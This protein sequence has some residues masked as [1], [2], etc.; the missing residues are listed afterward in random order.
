MSKLKPK[1]ALVSTGRESLIRDSACVNSDTDC[2]PILKGGNY[3]VASGHG[4]ACYGPVVGYH[5]PPIALSKAQSLDN[6]VPSYLPVISGASPP[7][8]SSRPRPDPDPPAPQN[9]SPPGRDP[10]QNPSQ[11]PPNAQNTPNQQPAQPGQS[12]PANQVPTVP[13]PPASHKLPTLT[14]GSSIYTPN[15]QSTYNIDG[16]PLI[17]GGPAILHSGTPISIAPYAT[18]LVIGTSTQLLPPPHA[19]SR[20]API[21]IA[22]NLILSPNPNP[23][24]PPGYIIGAQTLIP[25][26]PAAII[27]GTAVALDISGNSLIIDGT[28]TRNINPTASALIIGSET[29][30]R[31]PTG[32][33][34]L[35]GKTL[36]PGAAAITVDGTVVSLDPAGTAVVVDGTQTIDLGSFID[37]GPPVAITLGAH[38]VTANPDGRFVIGSQTLRPG[39]SAVTVDGTVYELPPSGAA[40]VAVLTLPPGGL[41]AL[42]MQGFDFGHSSTHNH[43]STGHTL[44]T[45]M[46]NDK[47]PPSHTKDTGGGGK[48]KYGN[49][50]G[51]ELDD[52]ASRKK[53][54][55]NR[56]GKRTSALFWE[57]SL[58]GIGFLGLFWI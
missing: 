39:G 37:Q 1:L 19:A 53:S 35:D 13:T 52:T 7:P 9:N 38:P 49:E 21:T 30:S 40:P 23:T 12:A 28:S 57:A 36:V 16:Q 17:P 11:N 24:A 20:T 8:K 45:T 31:N 14:I 55:G 41:G 33:Y 44:S 22:P 54:E 27:A 5:D 2:N 47:P 18:A 10:A 29:L 43:G 6:G 50:N 15:A 56:L 42:I 51:N 58:L 4:K 48:G 3:G 46:T 25:G 32:A 26:G 34:V